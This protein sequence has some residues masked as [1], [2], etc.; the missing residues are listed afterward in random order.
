[1]RGQKPP[2]GQEANSASESE[3]A[4]VATPHHVPGSKEKSVAR[5]TL[6]RLYCNPVGKVV[7]GPS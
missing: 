4:H 7:Q 1:M 3:I 6:A 5:I 2:V